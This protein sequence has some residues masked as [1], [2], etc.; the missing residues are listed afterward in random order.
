MRFLEGI[1]IA[2]ASLRAHKLRSFLTL[3]GVIFGVMTVVAVAAVIEGFFRYIDRTVTA[4]LGANTVILDKYG[5]ITSFEEFI[6]ANRRNK[7]ITLGDAD[8]L[9]ERMTLAQAIGVQGGNAAEVRAMREKLI[10]ISVRGVTPNMVSIES[11][12][13]DFGRYVSEIDNEHRR[14]VAMIGSEIA[15][16]LF[17]ARDVV[18]REI[19]VNGSPFEIVG[20]AKEQ[21]SFFGNSRDL[22][23]LIP[24][25]THQKVFGSHESL[26]ISIR[27][28]D[29]ARLDDVQD[30]VRMLMRARHRLAY[31]DKDTFGLITS[32]AINNFVQ[33]VF[34]MIAAVALGV[35]SI[36]L[37]VG[38]IVIMNIMLVTVTER[39]REIGIRKSL[40]A[41]RKDILAQFLVESTTLSLVGGLIGLGVA[42]GIS[43]LLV[44]FTPIPAE[45]PIWAAV[46]A[47]AVSS[48]VGLIFG[49]YPAWKAAKL[50]PIE[51]LRSE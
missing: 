46:L 6:N 42:Y 11:T 39:T 27:A 10:N 37:V 51:A 15:D 26:V 18:G 9:R 36:S 19:K 12:Q 44:K 47:I 21:G 29:G 48:G 40:G 2:L 45:L 4:D 22:F 34:G 24:L 7:D 25:S 38:G 33:T 43:V 31:S 32:D 50:D 28:R 3:L 30:Q 14:N 8:Y 16:K 17:G 1:K 5:L 23:V 41:R 49:I 35:V 20:V 13:V